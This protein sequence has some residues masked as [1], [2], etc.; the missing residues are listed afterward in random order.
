[1]IGI[2]KLLHLLC[3]FSCRI[4]RISRIVYLPVSSFFLL[5]YLIYC[6]HSLVEFF[7]FPEFSIYLFLI[8]SGEEGKR[9][10]DSF[11]NT[12]PKFTSAVETV[13]WDLRP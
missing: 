5:N 4:L 2:I 11:T 7:E 6:V 10:G 8:F 13:S 1:M 9:D 12:Q 3:S